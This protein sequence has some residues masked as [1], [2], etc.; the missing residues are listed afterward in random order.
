[1][2]RLL[3]S[4]T[5]LAAIALSFTLMSA[6]FQ[7]HRPV[8][9]DER[10]I[11]LPEV[12]ALAGSVLWVDARKASDFA[13]DHHPG[14]VNLT[15]RAWD[16]GMEHFLTAWSPESTVVVYCDASGCRSSH[17]VAAHL[18]KDLG[19]RPRVLTGGWGKIQG[20]RRDSP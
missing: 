4:C 14:A 3:L 17:H 10:A 13:I 11:S 8:W 12:T 19:I 18:E 15:E 7:G 9:S 6:L 20:L 1:M 5:V 2:L 16:A